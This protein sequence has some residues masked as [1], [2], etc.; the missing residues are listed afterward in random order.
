M[1]EQLHNIRHSLSHLMAMAVLEK[2]P[3]AKLAI[4]PVIDNGFYY[5]FDLPQ[6]LSPQ[7]LPQLEKRMK[8]MIGQN[9]PFVQLKKT[10]DEAKQLSANQP[11]K[12]ELIADLVKS[13]EPITYYQSG[14]F[15]DLCAGPHVTSTKEINA[16][17]FKLTHIAGAYWRGDE[18][19]KMLQRIYGVAFAT[20]QELDDYL[21]Q[22]E[23]AKKRDHRK[24]GQELDLFTFA[25]AVGKG[26]PLLTPRG[27]IIR[28]ELERFVVDEELKRGYQ[29]VFTPPLAKTEL[30]KTSGHYPYYK[31]TMYPVMKVDDDELIL[32]PMTCPHHFMLYKDKPRSYRELPIRFAELAYQFRYEKSGE[33]SGLM[34]VREFTLADAHMFMAPEQA[35]KEIVEVL[36]LIDYCNGKLGLKKGKDYTYR[37]SL[38]DRHD[39]KKYYKD[40]KAWDYAENVLRTVLKKMKAPFYEAAGE[41]AFYGPKIDVQMK[42]VNGQEDTA[43][44]VQYDFVLPKRF[45][46]VYTDNH[47]VEREPLVIHRAS[48]GCLERTLAFL[49]EHYAGAFPVW[50]SPVQ[51]QI[52]TVGKAHKKFGKKLHDQLIDAGIRSYLDDGNDTV[53]Y[54]IRQ[55][56]KM[57]VPYMLVI[58]DKEMKGKKLA[59]RIRG[60]KKIAALALASFIKRVRTEITD[61]TV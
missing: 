45:N 30:Y 49:I 3:D 9:I 42:R 34:R 35:E 29:H 57:K 50:L 12:L 6:P 55:A 40:D 44:T 52:L 56:E 28:R 11:Y 32:R 41:A 54:K 23:E 22:Q 4:G 24:L 26:L 21:K 19:N 37:L 20:K 59:V 36:K 17:A 46:L 31:D 47:G 25:D 2:F 53:G 5:D 14:K 48:I 18:K 15:T 51:V 8:K 39:A 10:G 38:G 43:F 33:L 60:Q 1:S 16:D 61:K 13:N 7:D 58:G 27:A